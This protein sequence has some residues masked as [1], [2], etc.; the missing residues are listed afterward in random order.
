M[1]KVTAGGER[2]N[3]WPAGPTPSSVPHSMA[4]PRRIGGRVCTLDDSRVVDH[5]S[6]HDCLRADVYLNVGT[7][8]TGRSTAVYV[9]EACVTSEPTS[10]SRPPI[11]RLIRNTHRH[12]ASTSGPATTGATATAPLPTAAHVRTAPKRRCGG[13]Q[14]ERDPATSVADVEAKTMSEGHTSREDFSLAGVTKHTL[15]DRPPLATSS[16][17]KPKPTEADDRPQQSARAGR[18]LRRHDPQLIGMTPTSRDRTWGLYNYGRHTS[19]DS[20]A[21]PYER[22]RIELDRTEPPAYGLRSL[23]SGLVGW[24]K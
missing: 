22:P 18:S 6:S 16:T 12:D 4:R 24:R 14:P 7:A 9:V 1:S 10:Q 15:R 23:S 8:P 3:S 17:T 21:S 20:T 19:A 13:R 5:A 2:C 11:G